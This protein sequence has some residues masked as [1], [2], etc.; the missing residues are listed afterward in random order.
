MWAGVCDWD[1]SASC[2]GEFPYEVNAPGIGLVTVTSENMWSIIAQLDNPGIEA[3]FIADPK[4]LVTKWAVDVTTRFSY[5]SD[6]NC[7]AFSG[8]YD[9][10]PNWWVNAVGVIQHARK[11]ASEWRAKRV[12]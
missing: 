7:P 5:C 11:Q 2:L 9:E 1:L 10:Q 4:Y 6:F 8:A 12:H 3:F